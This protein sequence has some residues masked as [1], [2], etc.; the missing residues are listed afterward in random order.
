MAEVVIGIGFEDEA[1]LLSITAPGEQGPKTDLRMTEQG[2]AEK[3]TGT[4]QWPFDLSK[5]VTESEDQPLMSGQLVVQGTVAAV[6]RSPAAA[7]AALDSKGNYG[8]TGAKLTR[9]SLAG[10]ADAVIGAASPN[11]LSA[12]LGKLTATPGT[13]I[14]QRIG[15]FNV[16][17]GEATFSD[18]EVPVEGLSV[19]LGARADLPA[20][21]LRVETTVALQSRTDL[22]AVVM[23]Y[24]GQPG[25]VVTRTG[26]S[27]IAA[28]LGYELLSKEMAELER[29]QEQQR[30]LALKE[31]AQRREDEKR[32]A[33]YQATR[34]ELRE[35][36][37][38]RRFHQAQRDKRAAEMKAMVD[39]VIKNGA[40]RS[41]VELIRHA[42][43]IEVRRGLAAV[44][45][46]P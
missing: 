6:G 39:D 1:R 31:E 33:D 14:G 7:I 41:R 26:T 29:L 4:V 10:L 36:T 5:L 30:Q 38:V 23:T 35:Q 2:A 3:I 13:E 12:A 18:F 22:P 42:R 19:K 40:Q 20:Q 43:R 11:A 8:L 37:R 27:A 45:A 9:M 25:S 34:A 15:T 16:A 44:P 17:N 46:Q 21:R 28:K 32:F 24:E